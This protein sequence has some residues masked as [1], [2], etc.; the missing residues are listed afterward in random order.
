MLSNF[1]FSDG[2]QL[3]TTFAHPSRGA[4][5]YEPRE[6]LFAIYKASPARS[7]NLVINRIDVESCCDWIEMTWL[8]PLRNPPQIEFRRLV[9]ISK[10]QLFRVKLDQNEIL[11]NH[12]A[13]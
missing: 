11:G 6:R 7:L 4:E 8:N 12:I 13:F 1:T 9:V 3:P 10:K 5:S 2:G